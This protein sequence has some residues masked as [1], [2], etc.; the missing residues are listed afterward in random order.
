[1]DGVDV[2]QE[3]LK[4]V[5]DVVDELRGR[6][7]VHPHLLGIVEQVACAHDCVVD[8]GSEVPAGDLSVPSAVEVEVGV[9]GVVV[10]SE[11]HVNEVELDVGQFL[12][13]VVAANGR[14]ELDQL[15]EHAD[16][17]VEEI[18]LEAAEPLDAAANEHLVGFVFH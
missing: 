12:E 7:V 5:D 2:G 14:L 1:M 4:V 10:G 8:G 13:P 16:S 18:G 11:L 3:F 6:L 15:S 17:G 9:A